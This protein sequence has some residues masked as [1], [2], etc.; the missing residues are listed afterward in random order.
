MNK[1]Q[2]L[3]ILRHVL[4]FVG[5]LIVA[6]GYADDGT[7]TELIGGL[8]TVTGAVW[9][10]IA[11]GRTPKLPVALLA[12]LLLPSTFILLTGCN[13]I[14]PHGNVDVTYAQDGTVTAGTGLDIGTNATVVGTGSYN[15][16]T[17]QWTAGISIVFKDAATAAAAAA[18]L[19]LYNLG[20]APLVRSGGAEWRLDNYDADNR[21]HAHVVESALK[22]GATVKGI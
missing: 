13:T 8:L 1:D 12:F 17:G 16:S 9:S 5:G 3:G 10:I 20:P 18:D 21:Y 15:T 22:F 2:I 7:I 19:A 4:T 6:K 14:K 11:K